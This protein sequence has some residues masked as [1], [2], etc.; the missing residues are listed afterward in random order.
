MSIRFG[1][2]TAAAVV[3]FVAGLLCWAPLSTRLQLTGPAFTLASTH[4]VFIEVLLPSGP[5]TVGDERALNAAIA[6]YRDAGDPGQTDALTQYLQEFPASPWRGSLLANLALLHV[7]QGSPGKALDYLAAARSALSGASSPELQALT[8]KVVG[9]EL[10]LH[11]QLG[12]RDEVSALLATIGDRP[13]IGTAQED[14]YQAGAALWE[15]THEP[16]MALRCGLKALHALFAQRN[17]SP[18]ILSRIERMPA[19]TYGMSL[20]DLQAVALRS[21]QPVRVVRRSPS[22]EVPVPSVVHLDVG[23]F[24]A[25][26]ARDGDRFLVKDAVLGRDHW[27]SRSVLN[28][29]SS[30]YFLVPESDALMAAWQPATPAEARR[31]VGAGN[32]SQP[33]PPPRPSDDS[34]EKNGSGDGVGMPV[35]SISNA[36]TSLTLIDTPLAYTPP[37]GPEIAFRLKYFQRNVTQPTNPP[38]S[39]VGR[40]WTHNWLAYVQDNPVTAGNNVQLFSRDGGYWKY[41]GYNAATGTFAREMESRAQLVRV[42][43]NPVVYERRLVDGSVE[44]YAQSDGAVLAPRRIFLTQL[45]DSHGNAVTLEYDPQER[46]RSVTDA[47][48]QQTLFSY[49]DV[50]SALR[51]TA[52]TDP[53]GR[54]TTLSYDGNGRLQAITDAIGMTTTFAYDAG[55][56]VTSMSTPYGTTR[57][58]YGESGV[59]RWLT[60]TDPLGNTDRQE[61]RHVAPGIPFEEAQVP[62]AAPTVFRNAYIN[63]RNS[64]YWDK[65][66]V[67]KMAGGLDYTKAR[68]THWEHLL[69]DYSTP[70]PDREST[71]E[72]LENRTWYLYDGQPNTVMAGTTAKPRYAGRVLDNGATQAVR[73]TYNGI[74]N[75]ASEAD[76]LGRVT[77]YDYAANG[78]DVIAVRRSAGGQQETVAQFTYND[79]HNPLTFT[80]A[81]GQTTTYTYNDAGQ[82][83]SDTDPLGHTTQY[84]YD[85]SGYLITVINA[86]GQPQASYTY[87]SIGRPASETDAAGYRLEYEYDALNRLVSTTYPDGSTRTR[88]WDRLDV[89]SETDRLGRTTTASY[90]AARNRISES[91]PLGN[92]VRYEYDPAGRLVALTDANGS[93][94]RFE[95]DIQGRVVRK[96]WPDGGSYTYRYDSA[97]RL[98][99]RTDALGQE[100]RIGYTLDDNPERID[101]LHAQLPTPSVRLAYDTLYPRLV[102]MQDGT[103]T[104]SFRYGAAGAPGAQRLVEEIGQDGAVATRVDAYDALGRLSSRTLAGVSQTWARDAL[105]RVT[106]HQSSLGTFGYEY[107]GET[108]QVL[109]EQLAG[110]SWASVYRYGDNLSDRQLQAIEHPAP[111]AAEPVYTPREGFWRWVLNWLAGWFDD[112]EEAASPEGAGMIAY[113]TGPEQQILGRADQYGMARYTY[114]AAGRLTQVDQE[115]AAEDIFPPR[116][117]EPAQPP[118][119]RPHPQ[120]ES[121]GKPAS[122]PEPALSSRSPLATNKKPHPDNDGLHLGWEQGTHNPHRSSGQTS[123][124]TTYDYDPASNLVGIQAPDVESLFEVNASNQVLSLNGTAWQHDAN[125]NLLD[126]GRRGYVWD[127]ENRLL[128]ITDYRTGAVSNFFY[129]GMSRRVAQIEQASATSPPQETRYLWCGEAT[130]CLAY[131]PAGQVVS[132]YFPQGEV[133]EDVSRYYARDHLGSV[134]QVVNA[135]GEVLGTRRYDAYGAVLASGG[136]STLPGYAGMFWHSPSG[137]NLTWYRAY[138]PQ[139]GR[140]LSRD[141]IGEAGGINVY[142]YATN[143]PVNFI[144]RNGENPA[145]AVRGAWWAGTRIGA[146]INY[147]IQAATGITLGSLLYGALH[148]DVTSEQAAEPE[149]APP[150]PAKP[151]E[152]PGEG[153]EWR[154]KGAPGSQEGNWW[155]PETNGKLH[156]DFGHHPPK[157]SHWGYTD[158]S[159]NKWD[160]FPDRGW[161]PGNK[162]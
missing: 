66:V 56:F 148:T 22:Q 49:A 75:I 150:I 136:V 79:R 151:E 109:R 142:A 70:S 82:L 24:A 73:Y 149:P 156:P 33:M 134:A 25:V 29:E 16:A 98:T 85:G 117:Q 125:G 44:V 155:N 60:S 68:I 37:R 55:T 157:G 132:R 63:Y 152:C 107:L 160:H 18:A 61:F 130:P 90:D 146:G 111:A 76:P 43:A 80:D 108:G 140:W 17:V 52:V 113:T 51:I 161:V 119:A 6:A 89:V 124:S 77:Y 84:Q 145:S 27:V 131:S 8:D 32:T 28:T 1:K 2:T 15:M 129:D 118:E 99:G 97:G 120:G 123:S 138:D 96:I 135:S 5:V 95:R 115:T 137:L 87:D 91:D 78:M 162:K 139:A 100:R 147:G 11:A 128:Q 30:G 54:Q 12:H 94:T 34:C 122:L 101:Y 106:Q 9:A 64:F 35:C 126:D 39:H 83:T 19:K 53:I 110:K 57:Y 13:L 154:G 102:S 103:G 143:D 104:T 40:M 36:Q 41:S 71:K 116:R 133:T 10:R 72:P 38:Y 86:N 141:P 47:L 74:G 153:W 46:L 48:G 45:I 112:G 62:S 69:G 7:Q 14:K 67:Q 21:G 127:A 81:A 59:R 58:N 93:V 114:D 23:H 121:K 4:G 159:G 92:T 42:A 31:V 50:G 88:A 3:V 158:G 105:G 20:A 144:D 65:A 26:L